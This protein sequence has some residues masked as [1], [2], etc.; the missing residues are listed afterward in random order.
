MSSY[1]IPCS[2]S[3]DTNLL[4]HEEIEE[5]LKQVSVL[6]NANSKVSGVDLADDARVYTKLHGVDESQVWSSA[7]AIRASTGSGKE[8]TQHSNRVLNSAQ[9]HDGN[10]NDVSCRDFLEDKEFMLAQS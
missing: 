3:A 4:N 2:P 7:G 1:L 9:N 10:D 8:I 5:H 6:R